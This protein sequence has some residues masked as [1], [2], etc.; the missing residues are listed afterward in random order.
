MTELAELDEERKKAKETSGKDTHAKEIQGKE[1][2]M[3]AMESLAG[4][5]KMNTDGNIGEKY[6]KN[7]NRLL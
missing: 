6:I 2:R 4:T 1:I 7:M 5:S 3:A